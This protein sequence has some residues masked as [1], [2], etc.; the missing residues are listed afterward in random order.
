M[1]ALRK[2]YGRIRR[3]ENLLIFPGTFEKLV[4]KGIRSAEI[5]LHSDAVEAFDQAIRYEP[6]C[7]DFL[8]PYAVALYETKDFTRAKEI[9]N[10][11][12]QSG[13][14]NYIDS[15]ELYLTICI[16]LQQYEEVE[17]TIQMLIEEQIIPEEL[18][19][20]FNYLRELNNRLT[21]RYPDEYSI[22]DEVPFTLD[23]FMEMEPR[24]QHHALASLEGTDLAIIKP[25][26]IDIAEAVHFSPLVKTFALT[27][28]REANCTES[29]RVSKFGLEAEIIPA[30]LTLPGRDLKTKKVLAELEQIFLQDPTKLDLAKGLI[31]KFAITSFPFDWGD[32]QIQEIAQSYVKYIDSLFSGAELPDTALCLLIQR[33]DMESDL[34]NI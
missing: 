8:G 4:E 17:M 1:I 28:L 9:A 21:K 18:M 32:Y 16:Q 27:L 3:K 34:E 31:E 5:G 15:M 20:K 19:A 30:E 33:M 24:A 6:D 10:R 11:L 14:A 7:P 12:L 29:L 23:E 22:I 26:L 13:T 2:K 25:V